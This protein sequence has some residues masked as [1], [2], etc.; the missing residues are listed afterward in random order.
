MSKQAESCRIIFDKGRNIARWVCTQLGYAADE[1]SDGQA[2]GFAIGENLIGGVIYHNIRYGRDLWLT[3]YTA[4]KHWCS[5][6]NL[7]IIFG[8]AFD[9]YKVR[10]ISILVNSQNFI[11]LRFIERLGFKREGCL[12]SY[13]DTGTDSYIYGM[14]QSENLWKGNKNE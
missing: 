1:I 5:R 8:I 2:L 4:N 10:R 7:K 14:L 9:V 6:K 11:C 3:I 13:D 12:R